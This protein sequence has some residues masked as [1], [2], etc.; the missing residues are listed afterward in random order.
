MQGGG[1]T[2]RRFC[3]EIAPNVGLKLACAERDHPE[4]LGAKGKKNLG[5]EKKIQ[6]AKYAK[7]RPM[8]KGKK[9]KQIPTRGNSNSW[10]KNG[11][12]EAKRKSTISKKKKEASFQRTGE[13]KSHGPRAERALKSQRTIGGG[14]GKFPGQ[15]HGMKQ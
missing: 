4:N 13:N 9:K 14:G 8:A 15:G 1:K 12:N 7:N 5:K 11:K 10:R 3:K 6:G 2:R